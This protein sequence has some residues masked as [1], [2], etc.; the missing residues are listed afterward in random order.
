MLSGSDFEKWIFIDLLSLGTMNCFLCFA[1]SSRMW[2]NNNKSI[3]QTTPP[4]QKNQNNCSLFCHNN[5]RTWSILEV[6]QITGPLSSKTGGGR[7]MRVMTVPGHTHPFPQW[8]PSELWP[9][10]HIWTMMATYLWLMWQ[11][12]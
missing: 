2:S 6:V 8:E 11:H 10:M 9:S 7:D 4:L 1:S 3:K 5:G 12:K